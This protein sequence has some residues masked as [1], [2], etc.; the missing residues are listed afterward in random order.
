MCQV[1]NHLVHGGH[2]ISKSQY[3]NNPLILFLTLLCGVEA[4]RNWEERAEKLEVLD[5]EEQ[6]FVRALGG[7]RSF[8]GSVVLL[9]Q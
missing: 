2:V 9:G 1:L 4:G 8:G 3:H 5:T 6:G 7:S